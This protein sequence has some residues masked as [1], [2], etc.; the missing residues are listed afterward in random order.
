MDVPSFTGLCDRLAARL[1]DSKVTRGGL[2]DIAT[3][4]MLVRLD[5]EHEVGA[6]RG[7]AAWQTDLTDLHTSLRWIC[8]HA[9]VAPLGELHTRVAEAAEA[10]ARIVR[11]EA[12]SPRWE[13]SS[14]PLQERANA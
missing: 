3:A 6:Q 1:S 2:I 11:R 7:T 8:N 5:L 14:Q 13:L 4:L 12:S 10:A 9:H